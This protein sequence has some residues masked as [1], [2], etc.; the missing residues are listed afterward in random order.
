MSAPGVPRRRGLFR[1]SSSGNLSSSSL[2]RTSSLNRSGTPNNDRRGSTPHVSPEQMATVEDSPMLRRSLQAYLADVEGSRDAVAAFLK[3]ADA[4]TRAGV[5]Y[6]ETLKT[7]AESSAVTG[8][9][10]NGIW[11]HENTFSPGSDTATTPPWLDVARALSLYGAVLTEHS[12]TVRQ[13]MAQLTSSWHGLQPVAGA[14]APAALAAL[15]QRFD[16]ASHEHQA[17]VQAHLALQRARAPAARLEEAAR[18]AERATW[19]LEQSR[20]NYVTALN[21]AE[22]HMHVQL[23]ASVGGAFASHLESAEL[24]QVAAYHPPH[25][26]APLP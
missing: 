15:R 13:E 10:L 9:H 1:N 8:A 2:S 6:A 18:R 26:L 24:L 7:L 5:Q 16:R 20:F 14:R 23:M 19:V 12:S 25:N 3:N 22:A 4:A 17:A 21:R 11:N